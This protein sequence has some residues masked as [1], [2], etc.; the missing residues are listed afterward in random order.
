MIPMIP[1]SKSQMRRL[2]FSVMT[3]PQSMSK[4]IELRYELEKQG[5][6]PSKLRISSATLQH[7]RDYQDSPYKS[8]GIEP[9]EHINRLLG[10]D[11]EEVSESG[12]L[13]VS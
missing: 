5:I 3:K 2:A 4:I 13:E 1:Q 11:I 10:L 6:R 12:V 7:I 9:P 8:F